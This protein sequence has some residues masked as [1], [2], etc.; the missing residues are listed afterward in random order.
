[1]AAGTTFDIE[2]NLG[3]SSITTNAA[4]GTSLASANAVITLEAARITQLNSTT[5]TYTK[6]DGSSVDTIGDA[7]TIE[8]NITFDD[9]EAEALRESSANVY[10]ALYDRFGRMMTVDAWKVDLTD[11][12]FAFVQTINIPTNI[13]IG[14]IKIMVLSDAMVPLMAAS[15]LAG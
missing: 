8:A 6:E 11:L 15:E 12:T 3:N 13:E 2:V 10:L 7:E 14:A 1:M 5:V 9:A 4:G